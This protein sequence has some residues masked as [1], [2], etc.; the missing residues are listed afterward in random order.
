MIIMWSLKE[1]YKNVAVPLMLKELGYKNKMALPK[2]AKVV[3]DIGIGSVK[4]ENQKNM[5]EKQLTDIVGQKL[6]KSTAKKSIAS[7][8]TRVGSHIGYNVSLRGDRMY[9]FLNKMIYVAIPRRRDFR[10]LN[11]KSI[12]Q[13][14][15]LTIGFKEHI[16]FPEMAGE[17]IKNS[18][19]FGV[20]I[21]TTSR[22]KKE[23]TSLFKALSFPFAKK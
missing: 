22:N 9:D 10:G 15:N 8:K 23:A 13:M 7:F 2:I 20:T 14:G 17:D 5:I 6:V 1:Q 12:D 3:I 19:G 18:F 11:I 21:V 4:D 16:V